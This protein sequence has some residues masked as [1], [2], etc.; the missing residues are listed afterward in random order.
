L[1]RAGPGPPDLDAPQPAPRARFSDSVYY[2]RNPINPLKPPPLQP[3]HSKGFRG[4]QKISCVF[5][6]KKHAKTTKKDKKRPTLTIWYCVLFKETCTYFQ[7]SH[8]FA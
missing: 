4:R 8:L 5:R 6:D 7:K 1:R 3:S 2:A